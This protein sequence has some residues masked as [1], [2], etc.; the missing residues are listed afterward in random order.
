V[1]GRGCIGQ[2]VSEFIIA[3]KLDG[4]DTTCIDHLQ[5]SPWFMTLT[6]PEP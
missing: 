1:T 2:L 6:G 5:A 4:L 3:G